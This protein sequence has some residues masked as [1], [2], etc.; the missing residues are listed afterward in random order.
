MHTRPPEPSDLLSIVGAVNVEQR[1]GP[2]LS[3]GSVVAMPTAWLWQTAND[4]QEV[5]QYENKQELSTKP[6]QPEKVDAT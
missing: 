1:P 2:A 4:V 6:S 3:A 5:I